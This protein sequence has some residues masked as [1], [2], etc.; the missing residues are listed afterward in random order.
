MLQGFYLGFDSLLGVILL[1]LV[2]TLHASYLVFKYEKGLS[3]FLWVASFLFVPIVL[4]L[5]YIFMDM[6]I[7]RE[8]EQ[9]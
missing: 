4:S 9:A 7:T 8:E 5:I 2:S 6:F 3:K 1:F